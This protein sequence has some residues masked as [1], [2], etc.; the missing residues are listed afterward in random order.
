[1]EVD[2]ENGDDDLESKDAQSNPKPKGECYFSKKSPITHLIESA[3]QICWATVEDAEDVD[4]D[5]I[6]IDINVQSIA[7]VLMMMMSMKF[8]CN[9]SILAG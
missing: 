3:K 4:E 2:S 8:K 9:T 6:L 7:A 5:G 1:L